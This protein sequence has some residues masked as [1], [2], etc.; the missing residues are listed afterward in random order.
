ME[1]R[2]PVAT[3][4][5]GFRF[6]PRQGWDTALRAGAVPLA[7][8]ALFVV[9]SLTADNFLTSGN[10][11]NLLD[12]ATTLGIIASAGT[13]V[14]VAGGFDLSVGA[15]FAIAGVIAAKVAN[16][17]DPVLGLLAGV[18]AGAA[19][20]VANGLLVSTFRINSFIATIA[21]GLMIR[22]GA[23]AITSGFLITVTATDFEWLGVTQFGDLKLSVIIFAAWA[24]AMAFLLGRTTFGRHVYACGGNEEAARLSGIRVGLV[25]GATFL[26]SGTAAGLAGVIAASQ[27]ASGQA[28]AGTGIELTAIAAIVVGGASVRG[29]EGAVWRTVVGVLLLAMIGNGF[30]LLGIDPVYQN[31]VYGGIILAAVGAD[32]R[33]RGGS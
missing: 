14:V 7:L 2:A 28:D 3:G 22:G 10:L 30:N 1:G 8:L 29:G 5:T 15:T 18:L 16:S 26:L 13:L 9:L 24:I 17:S 25:R 32:A 27:V 21:S 4:A 12:Q 31:L 23:L 33:L 6:A 20:G 19:I 11:L